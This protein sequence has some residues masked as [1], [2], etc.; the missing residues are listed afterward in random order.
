MPLKH[1]TLSGH[2]PYGILC[3]AEGAAHI[4]PE[5][6]AWLNGK[7]EKGVAGWTGLLRED[8]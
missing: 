4:W 2:V 5:E 3:K 7:V 6:H 8:K 1:H